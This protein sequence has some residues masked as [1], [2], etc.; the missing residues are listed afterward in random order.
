MAQNMYAIANW[1][2]TANDMGRVAGSIPLQQMRLPAGRPPAQGTA[3][4]GGTL[5]VQRS[6]L[7]WNGSIAG[8]GAPAEEP[9]DQFGLPQRILFR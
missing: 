9:G 7:I 8:D 4:L 6:V 2:R 3:R 5:Q 1:A